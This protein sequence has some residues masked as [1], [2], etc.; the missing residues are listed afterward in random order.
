MAII[1]MIR[2]NGKRARRLAK[3]FMERESPLAFSWEEVAA[4]SYHRIH[5]CS[6]RVYRG[7]NRNPSQATT[8]DRSNF[9]V[10]CGGLPWRWD[11]QGARLVHFQ[12]QCSWSG[13]QGTAPRFCA[14]PPECLSKRTYSWCRETNGSTCVALRAGIMARRF[15][16]VAT[17]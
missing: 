15:H 1:A 14:F 4:C 16:K 7:R 3:W 12:A 9:D 10:P 5:T 6:K 11:G 8:Y 17:G 13:T 2:R